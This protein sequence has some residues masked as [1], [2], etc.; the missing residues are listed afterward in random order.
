M[1]DDDLNGS[2]TWRAARRQGRTWIQ[3]LQTGM[4]VLT[5]LPWPGRTASPDV[6]HSDEFGDP[7]E[8]N[9]SS[10]SDRTAFR[11]L[12]RAVRVFPVI[13][14]LIGLAGGVTYA[15]A[16]GL[17]LPGLV[18]ALIAVAV[19]ALLTGALHEDG[20]ADM[21]D[22]FGGGRT[23]EDK[24]ALMRDSRIGAYGVLA[25]LL[26]VAIKVGAVAD[27]KTTGAAVAGLIAA[28]AASRAV[29]PALMRWVPPSRT[30]GLSA[31]AGK[32]DRDP[33]WMGIAIAVVISVVLLSWTGIVALLVC[34][35]GALVIAW[36][37]K[38]Q[39]GGQTGDV[40]GAAQQVTELLFL[41]GLAAVR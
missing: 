8:T 3:D 27:M 18:A 11:P 29:M 33:V 23:R 40:L 4:S 28:G 16:F 38:R 41:L 20:L 30:D 34:G 21:A 36:L 14:A 39:I 15:I 13:G 35:I 31:M 12:G 1:Y 25:L 7:G 26:V 17:G 24:L 10:A 37:A 6:D 5:R 9:S 19:T 2:R 22:G 32:P